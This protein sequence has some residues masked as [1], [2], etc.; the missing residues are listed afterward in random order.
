MYNAISYVQLVF[1]KKYAVIFF[2]FTEHFFFF[3]FFFFK[4]YFQ[5]VTV[6]LIASTQ[7]FVTGV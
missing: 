5:C 7:S 1:E 6:E 3:F 4:H 2:F